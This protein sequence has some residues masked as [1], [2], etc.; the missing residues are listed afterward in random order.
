[1]PKPHYVPVVRS[2]VNQ[3]LQ[4]VAMVGTYS[5]I[6]AWNCPKSSISKDHL[7]FAVK[8]R[9]FDAKTGREL[10][11]GFLLSDKRFEGVK[12]DVNEVGSDEAPFQR[13]RWNDYGLNQDKYYEYEVYA[14]KGE[15]GAVKLGKPVK[16]TVVPS[17]E[18]QGGV[19]V[20]VNRGVTSARAYL[21]RFRNKHPNEVG[22]EAYEWLSRGLK[23][24]LLRFVQ[25][26]RVCRPR[27]S[28]DHLGV[29]LVLPK[30]LGV[31]LLAHEGFEH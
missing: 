14:A 1:M 4:A 19:G 7:G 12:E 31:P 6:I 16:L 20:Y 30:G 10:K 18:M 22:E 3:G 26:A 15:P 5:A 9:D 23:E 29:N 28:N 21:K 13:F 25:H 27:V 2:D 24:S 17:P 11:A 8:R